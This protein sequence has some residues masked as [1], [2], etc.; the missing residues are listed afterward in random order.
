MALAVL[1]YLEKSD[2]HHVFEAD[3]GTN[4]FYQ[5]KTGKEKR[6]QKGLEL[7]D[8]IMHQS[9]LIKAPVTHKEGFN[10]QFVFRIQEQTINRDNRFIQLFSYKGQNQVSPAIS[11]VVTILPTMNDFNGDFKLPK[12]MTLTHTHG[13]DSQIRTEYAPCHIK[14]NRVSEAMFFNA[15][16][17][18]LP[19]L[20][21]NALPM[22]GKIIPGLQKALPVV[23][24]KFCQ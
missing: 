4:T 10:T 22:I 8:G 18:A 14:E 5:Y 16:L 6:K 7:V 9:A 19:S 11:E 13:H 17:G 3:I 12:M 21:G 20:L 23:E 24:R 2:G 1:K 15:I